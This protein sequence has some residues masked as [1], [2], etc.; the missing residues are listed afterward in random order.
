[1]RP[2]V[3]AAGSD[4][5]P[6]LTDKGST[7]PGFRVIYDGLPSINQSR[8]LVNIVP[9]KPR[10]KRKRTAIAHAAP[11]SGAGTF[12]PEHKKIKL[13]DTGASGIFSPPKFSHQS[14]ISTR[15]NK[16]LPDRRD[17]AR[18]SDTET[19]S[20]AAPLEPGDLMPGNTESITSKETAYD[21]NQILSVLHKL[22]ECEI[23][24]PGYDAE[25]NK[26]DFELSDKDVSK[27]FD[28]YAALAS[29]LGCRFSIWEE[30]L[31]KYLQLDLEDLAAYTDSVWTEIKESL[32]GTLGKDGIS[33]LT[34]MRRYGRQCIRGRRDRANEKIPIILLKAEVR[35]LKNKKSQLKERI[36]RLLKEL[37]TPESQSGQLTEGPVENI[38]RP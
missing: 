10:G 28:E 8:A 3:I 31:L 7:V 12:T 20:L 5:Q 16:T 25:A 21:I 13:S 33:A 36:K 6:V 27:L 4:L 24:L 1:M 26:I 17:T 2:S 34:H 37:P 22:H 23:E 11:C 18:L 15:D 38:W 14:G 32:T 9:G 29:E 30:G 35:S 19:A